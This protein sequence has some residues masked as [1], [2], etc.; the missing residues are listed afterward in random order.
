VFYALI[1]TADGRRL[2]RSLGLVWAKRSQ[3]PDGYLSR[4]QAEVQLQA[5]LDG[6]D[7]NVP[8]HP[9][10]G[11]G[12]TFA[13]AG[14]EWLHYIEHDRKRR[15]ST[16]RDYR[17]ELEQVLIPAFGEE[18]SLT[19]ITTQSIDAYRVNLVMEGRLSP[20]TINKRLAQLHAIF[21]RA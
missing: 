17:R 5:M 16:V 15:P 10:A 4:A 7:E 19:D 13:Q 2:Q 18:T 8:V 21:K 1:R 9:P 12:V 20:R 3:P 14:R 6:S 11:S